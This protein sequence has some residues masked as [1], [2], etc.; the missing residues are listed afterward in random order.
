MNEEL[1]SWVILYDASDSA[2]SFEVDDEP[3]IDAAVSRHIDSGGTVDTLLDLTTTDGFRTR[4]R[5][6][7]VMAWFVST[8]ETRRR[9]V[10]LSHL[11]DEETKQVKADLGIWE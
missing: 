10:E 5:A 1:G 9:A 3:R 2:W 7:H 6:S 11:Q 4:I 8:P